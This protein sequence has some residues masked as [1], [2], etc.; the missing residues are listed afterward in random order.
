MTTLGV[1]L[2]YGKG[3]CNAIA[4]WAAGRHTPKVRDRVKLMEVAG[5]PLDAWSVPSVVRA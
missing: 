4:N 2:G 5:I 3:A 1:R